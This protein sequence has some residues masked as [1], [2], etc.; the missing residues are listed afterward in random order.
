MRKPPTTSFPA[1]FA[2]TALT[3]I[4]IAGGDHAQA[5]KICP[6]FVA[7]YC[8]VEKDG[9]RHTASTNPCFAEE[10]GA[11]VLHMGACEGRVCPQIYA[12]VCSTDPTTGTNKTYSNSCLSDAANATLVHK[13]KC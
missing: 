13:G 6:H 5:Q 11:R 7:E 2:A 9:A 10:R 8:V 4:S 3:A 12:P 1:I